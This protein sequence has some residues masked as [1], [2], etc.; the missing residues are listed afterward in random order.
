ML[1]NILFEIPKNLAPGIANG[2]LQRFGT[3]IKSVDSGKVVAHL[4]ETG[5]GQKLVGSLVGSPFSPLDAVSSLAANVQIAQVTKMVEALK[6]L[7]YANLGVAF[8][9][10]GVSVVGFAVVNRKLNSIQQSIEMLSQK[11]DDK[12][13]G[14]YQNLLHRD[15]HSIRGVLEGIEATKRL[16]NPKSELI[17]AATRLAEL[18]SGISGHLEHHVQQTTFDE[19]LFVQLAS[20]LFLSDNA[21][22]EAYIQANEYDS[23]HHNAKQVGDS[24]SELF[25]N[26]TAHELNQKQLVIHHDLRERVRG[27]VDNNTTKLKNLITGLRDITDASLTKPYFIEDLHRRKISGPDYLNSLRNETIEPFVLLQFED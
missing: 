11:L 3:I 13:S 22:I 5:A 9:G 26:L 1:N 15:L 20:A 21:R 27:R 17:S 16:S 23:A 8:A 4:Q 18:R 25:D 2:T 10:I 12:F 24:Y 19:Q 7:Q 6:V 14:L